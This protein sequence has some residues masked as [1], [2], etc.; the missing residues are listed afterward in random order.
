MP[1]HRLDVGGQEGDAAVLALVVAG[2]EVDE[3][4]RALVEGGAHDLEHVGDRDRL[5]VGRHARALDAEAARRAA[6]AEAAG[7]A[8]V[9]E[10]VAAAHGGDPWHGRAAAG[11]ALVEGTAR[12]W[13]Y[14]ATGAT[15]ADRHP[16]D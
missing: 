15:R 14:L 4:A 2:V 7:G 6:H 12:G 13:E 10:Q 8:R 16:D 1:A 5:A 9:H 3:L 11:E